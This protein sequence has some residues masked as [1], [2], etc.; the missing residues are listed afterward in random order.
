MTAGRSRGTP[1]T[2]P[3]PRPRTATQPQSQKPPTD[4]DQPAASRGR[5]TAEESD[6]LPQPPAGSP[7]SALELVG[8][9]IA[10]TTLLTALAFYFGWKF[11]NARSSY[12]GLDGSALGFSTR[13][14]LVRSADALFIPLGTVLTLTLGAIRLHAIVRHNLD[15]RQHARALRAI[16]RTAILGGGVLFAFG[17]FAAFKP[18]FSSHY[19]LRPASSGIGI[20]VLAYGL[21]LRGQVM[22]GARPWSD[23]NRPSRGPRADVALV[24][25]LAVLSAFWT[26]AVYASALGRG[27]AIEITE[28]LR[29]R[30]Q[31][32]VYARQRLHLDGPGIVEQRLAGPDSAYGYRYGGLRLLIRSDGKYFLL[33]DGWSRG[34]GAAIVLPDGQDLRFEFTAA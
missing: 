2:G 12:F 18:V 27:R 30:P 26:A 28:R 33:P 34:A 19:L 24:C 10:P 16:A 31:V 32:T 17:V 20:V 1:A 11:T 21:Y 15:H 22:A 7:R 23:R 14:Y 13:D 5:R 3:M 29:L 9:V 25:L 4:A 6:P 8:L